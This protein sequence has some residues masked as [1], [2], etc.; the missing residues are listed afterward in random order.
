MSDEERKARN[1]EVQRLKRANRTEEQK[2]ANRERVRLAR[3]KLSDEDK[4]LEQVK[5][6][7]AHQVSRCNMTDKQLDQEREQNRLSLLHLRLNL[8][9]EERVRIRDQNAAAHQLAR[10][11]Q[12]PQQRAA[13]N[14]NR[15]GQRRQ[16]NPHFNEFPSEVEIGGMNEECSHCGALYFR[17]QSKFLT[18]SPKI[19]GEQPR[20]RDGTYSPCCRNGAV[21]LELF[22]NYPLEL[23]ELFTDGHESSDNFLK[24]S[25]QF[26]TALSIASMDCTVSNCFQSHNK[27]HF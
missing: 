15:R 17:G 16:N 10:N 5:N 23:R 11:A 1:A 8:T 18:F 27:Q 12:T 4:K 24:Y 25:R 6:R 22:D 14:S 3:K 9:D 19:L 26:N 21:T 13:I 7:L 2:A 20:K